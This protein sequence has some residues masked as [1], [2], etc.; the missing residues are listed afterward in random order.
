MKEVD[1]R[2]SKFISIENFGSERA[3]ED[4]ARRDPKPAPKTDIKKIPTK[5]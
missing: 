2:S 3:A 5:A 4:K 1:A